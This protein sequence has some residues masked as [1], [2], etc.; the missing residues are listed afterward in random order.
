MKPMSAQGSNDGTKPTSSVFFWCLA[1]SADHAALRA[2]EATPL[3]SGRTRFA[4][5]RRA[6]P[7]LL[8]KVRWSVSRWRDG[9][10]EL[11]WHTDHSPTRAPS[12]PRLKERAGR[13]SV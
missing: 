11:V 13:R 4:S 8:Q 9:L 2:P 6:G 1:G 10:A 12:C 7:A 5:D 3:V